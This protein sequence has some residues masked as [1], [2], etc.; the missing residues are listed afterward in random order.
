MIYCAYRALYGEDFVQYSIRSI[1]PYVDKVFIFWDDVP[2]GDVRSCNYKGKRVE[3]PRKFDNVLELIKDLMI[4]E[5]KIVLQ[6][7]HRFN[8]AVYT[9]G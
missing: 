9:L 7:D 5:P 8:N 2:W 3:F 1:L 4:H 6:H